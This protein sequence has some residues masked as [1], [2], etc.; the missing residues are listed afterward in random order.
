MED[1]KKT[2]KDFVSFDVANNYYDKEEKNSLVEKFKEILFEDDVTVR[3][4]LE[5]FFI[6]TKDIAS[7]FDLIAKDAEVKPE[8]ETPET[9]DGTDDETTVEPEVKPVPKPTEAKQL[10]DWYIE[11]ASNILYE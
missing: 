7:N 10:K 4:F 5:K 3:K 9:N 1:I 2:I 6:S 8:E 11:I